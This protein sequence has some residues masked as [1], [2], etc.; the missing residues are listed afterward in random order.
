MIKKSI[1]SVVLSIVAAMPVA[2]QEPGAVSKPMQDVREKAREEIRT[3]KDT[4]QTQVKTAQDALRSDAMQKREEFRKMVDAKRDE[5]KTK[6]DAERAALKDKLAKIRD[7]RK[8][9]AVE[10]IAEEIN[11]LN[12]NRVEHYL[13]VVEKLEKVLDNIV[14]R[15]DK[16]AGRGLDVAAVRTAIEAA[17]TAIAAAKTAIQAQSAKTYPV[18]VTTEDRLKADVGAARKAL[19]ADLLKVHEA[20]KAARE[21]VHKAATTLAQIPKVDDEPAATTT[22][23]NTQ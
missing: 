13:A 19:H 11:R 18:A 2:A 23:T 15:T 21:A 7:E 9:A 6:I 3:L 10:R 1:L 16:A 14:S 4:L 20:V 22:P 5:L 17:K 8:K 12:D